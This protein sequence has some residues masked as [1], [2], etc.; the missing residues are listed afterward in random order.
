MVEMGKRSRVKMGLNS[1]GLASIA[2]LE[3]K[4]QLA[5]EQPDV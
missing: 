4:E 3:M 5:G 2:E 1:C